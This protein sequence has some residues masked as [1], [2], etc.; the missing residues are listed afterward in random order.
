MPSRR[1]RI[2]LL[3]LSMGLLALC[4][5]P[6]PSPRAMELTAHRGFSARCPENTM[7]AFRAAADAGADCIELD[8]RETADHV[9][10][11]CHDE[12]LARTTGVCCPVSSLCY[13]EI[14]ELDAGGWFSPAFQGEHLPALEE[15]LALA[16][17]REIRLNLE[18]KSPAFGENSAQALVALLRQYGAETLCSVSCQSYPVLTRIKAAGPELATILVASSVPEDLGSLTDADA[19]SIALRAVTPELTVRVHRCGKRLLI[20]DAN[21]PAELRRVA[22]AKPDGIITDDPALARQLLWPRI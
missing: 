3:T 1:F 22:A 20:W 8:I 11:V 6:I 10:V 18:I 12:S 7:A 9:F 2:L 5:Q 19:L 14:A 15:V 13:W 4:V 16:K 21:T 17:Q